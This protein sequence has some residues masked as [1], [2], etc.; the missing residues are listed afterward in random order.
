MK[1]GIFTLDWASIKSA[2]ISTLLMAILA[3]VM[4]I[5]GLGDIWSIDAKAITN[6]GV[7]A[8]L[9]G[10]VSLVKSFLSTDGGKFMGSVDI[11]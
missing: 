7:M 9:T 8:F 6:I 11:K 10:I 1:N 3:M 2:L 4:Y 5:I